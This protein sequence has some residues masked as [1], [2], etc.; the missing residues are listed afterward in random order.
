MRKFWIM[1]L[2]AVL[3]FAMVGCSSDDTTDPTYLTSAEQFTAV[4]DALIDYIND[5]PAYKVMDGALFTA[6]V[7]DGDYT[8]LDFRTTA[9]FVG[10]VSD[11]D[12]HIPGAYDTSLGTLLADLEGR[13]LPLD[14]PFMCVCY[15]GQE[16][17][18]AAIALRA[19]GYEAYVLKFGMCA[20]NTALA[21]SW[22]NNVGSGV[23]FFTDPFTSTAT[24]DYPTL[25]ENVTSEDAAVYARVD[26]MLS[27]SF[28]VKVFANI[29]ATLDDY[30]IVNYFNA[31]DYAGDGAAP[32]HLY[33]AIQF[34]PAFDLDM[35]ERLN[36]LPTE[37][38]ILVY[39]WTG[40]TS[41]QITAY[42]NMLGYDAYSLKFGANNMWYDQLGGHL[43]NDPGATYTL[44]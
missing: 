21:G 27:G 20:Y 43:W 26:A 38:P 14:K 8:I 37:E 4:H 42:L 13:T 44:D 22:N 40:H 29:A 36:N 18:H 32:G 24:Y 9:D 11:D 28:K 5:G 35:A 31:T 23:P 12:G 16:A 1:L 19:Q 41:S 30:F 33:G 2:P 6:M 7:T 10:T 15:S 39:C 3:L 25:D 34:T 17:G